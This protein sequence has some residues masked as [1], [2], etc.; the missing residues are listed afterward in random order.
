MSRFVVEHTVEGTFVNDVT[1]RVAK[2]MVTELVV[3]V[4]A[5]IKLFNHTFIV[6]QMTLFLD[7]RLVT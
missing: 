3:H 4:A 6:L 2:A 1:S 7:S 5:S